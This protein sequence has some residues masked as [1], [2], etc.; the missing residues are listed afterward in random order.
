M[1]KELKGVKELK[2]KADNRL[3]VMCGRLS[4]RSSLVLVI[5]SLTVFAVLAVYM[6]ISA[7]GYGQKPELK[8]EHIEGLQIPQSKNDS[9]NQ[10][11]IRNHDQFNK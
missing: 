10:L 11:K 6:A 3:R 8:I 7:I 4:P 9:I 2:G 1:K 5:I